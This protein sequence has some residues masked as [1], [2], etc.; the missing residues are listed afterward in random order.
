MLAKVYRDTLKR[1]FALSALS[2]SKS[3]PEHIREKALSLVF[4]VRVLLEKSICNSALLTLEQGIGGLSSLLEG[5]F[6]GCSKKQGTSLRMPLSSCVPTKLCAGRCY[7]HDGRDAVAASVIRG[8]LNG[9]VA[10]LYENTSDEIRR[11]ILTALEPHTQRA[12]A[13]A[14]NEIRRLSPDFSRRPYIRFSHVGEIAAFPEFANALAEQVRKLSSGSVDCV[15]YTRH[16][17]AGNLNTKLLVVNFTLDQSSLERRHWS[18]PGTR[19]VSSAFDGYLNP[20]VDVNFLEHHLFEHI[21][22]VGVGRI[23][24]ATAPET[25]IRTCDAVRCTHCFNRPSERQ[26]DKPDWSSLLPTMKFS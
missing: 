13:N 19:L 22:P 11:K 20:D 10:E 17:K 1:Y 6:F 14:W 8:A 3:A 25:R 26:G 12:I 9:I 7:A 15:V 4:R 18:P 16:P 5:S 23:C 24:P 2:R 21:K